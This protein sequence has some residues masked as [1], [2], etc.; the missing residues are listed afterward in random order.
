MYFIALFNIILEVDPC[1]YICLVILH[2]F[3]IC[4]VF[5]NDYTTIYCLFS[6]GWT[7]RLFHLFCY[8]KQYCCEC[9]CV[10]HLV[11]M[12][13]N[14][15]RVKP[16]SGIDGSIVYFTRCQITQKSFKWSILQLIYNSGSHP[17]SKCQQRIVRLLTLTIFI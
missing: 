17:P 4:I 1:S 14:L 10:C 2:S 7:L 12:C 15:F 3:S 9:L 16:R 13:K 5:L 8:Y 6:C 11:H